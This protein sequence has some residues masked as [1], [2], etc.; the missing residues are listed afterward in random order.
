MSGSGN[1]V[2]LLNPGASRATAGGFG[3]NGF[4][5]V[6]PGINHGAP[7]HCYLPGP[8]ILFRSASQTIEMTN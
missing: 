1:V 4:V 7:L 8:Q 2:L 6:M 5:Y 3:E